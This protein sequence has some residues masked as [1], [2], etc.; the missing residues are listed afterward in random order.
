[1][2]IL[3]SFPDAKFK[4]SED[5]KLSPVASKLNVLFPSPDTIVIPPPSAAASFAAPVP[6]SRFLSSTVIVVEFTV[7]VVPSIWRSPA[8]TTVPVLSPTAAG[9]IVKVAGPLIVFVDI[10]I[11]VPLAPVD[12]A[13]A[14]AVPVTVTPVVVVSNFLESL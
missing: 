2:L 12:R 9:S 11:P 14:S 4:F 7:V 1:M 6:N 8:I 10:L 13:V 3:Y 5:P